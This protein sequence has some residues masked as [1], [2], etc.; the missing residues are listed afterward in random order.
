[1]NTPL[2]CLIVAGLALVANAS[3]T[4]A[5][6]ASKPSDPGEFSIPWVLPLNAD[7]R[8]Q[9]QALVD[10]DPQAAAIAEHTRRLAEPLLGTPATPLEVIHYEG[11]VNT[12]PRRVETV[13]SL[14]Q[15]G[16]AGWVLRHWQATEDPAAADTLRDWI[17]AWAT[18]YRFTG[19]DVNENKFV[20]LLVAYVDLREGFN[21]EDQQAADTL[22]R[23]LGEHHARRA[24]ESQYLT[25][26]FAKH[27]RIAALAG[28]ALDEP[29]WLDAARDG[30]SRFVRESL[31]PDGSSF[32]LEH[33]DTLTYHGSALKPMIELSI[34]FDRDTDLDPDSD[35]DSGSQ[36]LYFFEGPGGAS[37]AKSV[38][39]VVP[40][41]TGAKTREEWKNS[42]VEL[43]RQRAEAGLEYFQPGKLYD[44]KQAAELLELAA[45]YRP[46]LVPL[47]VQLTDAPDKQTTYPTWLILNHTALREAR[48]E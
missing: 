17:A 19:N 34:L 12:D 38:E 28:L 43:D 11:L 4:E 42:E 13:K 31:R 41:A 36:P 9:L 26:R 8:R 37:I 6:D 47:V 15:M 29:G 35:S 14:R 10:Q 40:Y 18:T 21:P 32:D 30:V 25:N 46:D 22:F 44:P 48:A 39:F 23:Q 33:R 24:R 1:M 3:A 16:D 7:E 20:P 27:L 5:A 2:F 45:Y